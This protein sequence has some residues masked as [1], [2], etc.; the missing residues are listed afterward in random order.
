MAMIADQVSTENILFIIAASLH[1]VLQTCGQLSEV[2][3]LKTYQNL[4]QNEVTFLLY[5]SVW[6]GLLFFEE[7]ALL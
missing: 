1:V 3:S 2:G 7:T 5:V 4:W 6:F